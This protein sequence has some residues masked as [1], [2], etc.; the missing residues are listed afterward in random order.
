MASRE[1]CES[2]RVD[3][4]DGAGSPTP[5]H[6]IRLRAGLVGLGLEDGG[7]GFPGKL[8]HLSER[9]P[10][11]V[12]DERRD[13]DGTQPVDGAVEEDQEEQNADREEEAGQR[14]AEARD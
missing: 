5:H 12:G 9:A 14:D 11:G 1:T 6:E 8:P 2:T 13:R 10:A 7:V 4:L 3:C